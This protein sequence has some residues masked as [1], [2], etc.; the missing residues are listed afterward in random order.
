MFRQSLRSGKCNHTLLVVTLLFLGFLGASV[1]ARADAS[2]PNTPAGQALQAFFDAFNSGD[3]NRIAAYVK[4]YDPTN[5]TDGLVSFSGQSGGFN[6]VSVVQSAPDRLT[7]LV[8]GRGD[9]IDAYGV[10]QLA[11]TTPPQVK[12]LNIRALPPGA[13][14]EDIQLDAAIR[15]K[16]IDAIG[17]QLT[18]HYVY[19]DVATKMIQSVHEHQEH[20]DYNSITDGNEF[21]DALSRDLR[22]VSHD[23]HLFVGY[24]PY[25]TPEVAGFPTG[26]HEPS[27]A[28]QARF[29]TMLEHQNCTFSK[30][31]ILNHNIGYIKFDAFPPAEF[32]G[33]TV[34]AAMS[35]VANAD[36]LIFDLR[37]NHGGDPSMVD[38]MVSYLF[39]QPTHIN[40]LA[41]RDDN[42]THQYWTLP[43]VPGQR[44][45]DKPVYVLTSHGTFSGGE[46]FT[47]DLKT[48]KRATIVGE[49]TGGG[50]HPVRG[51]PAGDHF[52]IGVPFAR[53]INPVTKGDWEGTGVEPD[54]KVSAADAL[55]AAEKLAAEKLASTS[56]PE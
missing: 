15:Q 25:L 52:T 22:S 16:T 50:A 2:I 33:P 37:E 6:F 48:Q 38:F 20:G 4:Q 13:K 35:F 3:H 17:K 29:R 39:R 11:G 32:C 23:Q 47:F 40:D 49:V 41:A 43:W 30:L 1:S 55:A 54:V 7:F 53:P 51:M 24:D 42:E 12:R 46:E 14:L 45:I 31:E 8:H 10:L 36:A 18:E 44:F 34:V 27:P 56:K 9:G 5:N 26:P 21:A 19:P 28:E